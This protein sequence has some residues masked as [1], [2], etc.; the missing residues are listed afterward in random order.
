MWEFGGKLVKYLNR[1]YNIV[2]QIGSRYNVVHLVLQ[3]LRTKVAIRF[4]F[5]SFQLDQI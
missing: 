4:C 1:T 3:G 2:V 5:D